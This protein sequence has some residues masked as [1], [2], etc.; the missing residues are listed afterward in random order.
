MVKKILLLGSGYVARPCADYL[1]RRDDNRLTVA[2]RRIERARALCPT[3]KNATAISLDVADQ[4]ALSRAVAEHDLVISLVPYT[5][6]AQV[7]KA[8]IEHKKHVVT[9]SYISPAMAELHDA[10]AKAGITVFNEIGVDP[11]VDHLYALK[12]IWETHEAGGKMVHFTSYCGGLPA[13]ECSNNPLGYKFSWSS[14]GVL[15]A[16]RNAAKYIEN[17]KEKV[18]P[19]PELLK[20]AKPIWTGYPAFAFEGYPN[21]DSTPYDVRYGIPEAQTILRGTLRY[22]GFPEFMQAM[23]DL[24]FLDDAERPFLVESS[25]AKSWRAVLASML[26]LPANTTT[27]ALERAVIAK[28]NPADAAATQR[29]LD[30][31]RWIGLF[32]ASAAAP[33]RGNPLDSLCATLEAK[34][35]YADGE[36]DMVFLQHRFEIETKDGQRKTITSTLVEYGTEQA[37]AMAKTVGVPCGV[38]TQLVLDGVITTRGVI[39]PMTRETVFPLIRELEK[40]GI[41]M[42]EVMY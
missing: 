15:L 17:G 39:A 6:H 1:L 32:D 28:A 31:M 5:L 11:G 2:S 7:I 24:G 40:E 8:A 41:V 21:R 29:L 38:A 9:T 42:H 3:H 18:I 16:L 34:M 30:G 37:S 14:R 27:E 20:S 26:G 12:T 33:L 35:Q 36:R 22:Q 23:V 19:G 25:G 10:A 13:P 4:A